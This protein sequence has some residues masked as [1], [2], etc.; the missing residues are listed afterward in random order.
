MLLICIYRSFVGVP[1]PTESPLQCRIVRTKAGAL[2]SYDNYSLFTE[3]PLGTFL[4]AARTRKKSKNPPYVISLN[5]NDLFR[6]SPAYC[7]KIRSNFLGTEFTVLDTEANPVSG[8]LPQGKPNT[9][10]YNIGILT[11]MGQSIL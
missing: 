7:G 11:D 8:S 4:L 1:G 3:G 2:R 5:A 9:V 10:Y 6:Q